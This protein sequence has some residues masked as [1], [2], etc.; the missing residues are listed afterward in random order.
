MNTENLP[1]RLEEQLQN[2]WHY[3]YAVA[4]QAATDSGKP[5]FYLAQSFEAAVWAKVAGDGGV[6]YR[7][8]WN[9]DW[10]RISWQKIPDR[11]YKKIEEQV[12]AE[13]RRLMDNDLQ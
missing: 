1:P 8:R 4:T 12:K 3:D 13:M 6:I 2:I 7:I 10:D 11:E 9:P 5:G